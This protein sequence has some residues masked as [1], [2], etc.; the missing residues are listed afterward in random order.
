MGE[1]EG[2]GSGA[3][4]EAG[5][6]QAEATGSGGQ[7]GA[8]KGVLPQCHPSESPPLLIFLHKTQFIIVLKT[9]FQKESSAQE[10]LRSGVMDGF[11]SMLQFYIYQIKAAA[12]GYLTKIL[13][14]QSQERR[15]G[16]ERAGDPILGESFKCPRQHARGRL[17]ALGVT[18]WN[19]V[20]FTLGIL[21][22]PGRV[23]ILCSL[24]SLL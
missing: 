13:S 4:P 18:G 19:R 7:A 5:E 2:C 22:I 23:P 9:G 24:L 11:M 3:P 20:V 6:Q 15:W 14:H 21:G 8:P 1:R 12:K 10:L 17:G 16:R